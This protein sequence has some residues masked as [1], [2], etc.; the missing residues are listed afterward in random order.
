MKYICNPYNQQFFATAL[1]KNT[2]TEGLT[3]ENANGQ[4][5]IIIQ[6]AFGVGA[7]EKLPEIC[8]ALSKN[9]IPLTDYVE[10]MS[11]YWALYV[12]SADKARNNGCRL[13]GEA[14]TYT[15][16]GCQTVGDVCNVFAPQENAVYHESFNVPLEIHATI[17][18]E[19]IKRWWWI[20]TRTLWD[21]GFYSITFSGGLAA[22]YLDES[23][24][25]RINGFEFPVTREMLLQGTVYIKSAIRPELLPKNNG[26]SIIQE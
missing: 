20:F 8:E 9:N 19:E 4:D 13:H 17:K 12:S 16:F 21:T 14:C 5:V 10:I 6:S 24:V 7:T 11:G 3:W 2:N 18:K 15:V 22:S 1:R 26:I 23:L 25:Y